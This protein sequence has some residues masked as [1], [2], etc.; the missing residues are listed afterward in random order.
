MAA[1]ISSSG[2]VK[3]GRYADFIAQ[4]AEASK[5]YQ[6]LGAAP[7]RLM[8]AGF[9][10]EAFGT[11]TFTVE[12]DDIESLAAVS[13]QFAADSEAQ[14]YMLRLQEEHSPTVME[15]VSIG[16]EVPLRESKGGRGSVAAV[17]VVKPHPG[18]LERTLELGGRVAAFGESQGAVDVRTFSLLGAG[19]GAGLYLTILE[20]DSLRAYAKVI[21]A[22]ST[23]PEGQ[24]IA[25][26]SAGADA[27]NTIVFEAVYSEI[28]LG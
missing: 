19:S 6:R 21:D 28:P 12:C 2:R 25:A 4:A 8:T 16:I 24:A 23:E 22:F 20:F 14:A 3:P 27:P 18:G 5:L 26:T 13:D 17:Y 9:A 10:G 7:P 15:Q 1:I 11:W